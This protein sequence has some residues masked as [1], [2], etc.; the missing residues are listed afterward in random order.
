MILHDVPFA[1]LFFFALGH[2][3]QLRSKNTFPTV[4]ALQ[5][6]SDSPMVLFFS[7]E[8]GF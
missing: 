8:H 2:E 1:A 3:E 5:E 4:L 7:Q 6:T